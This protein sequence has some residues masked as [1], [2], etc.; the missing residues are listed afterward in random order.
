[1]K[2]VLAALLLFGITPATAGEFGRP[3]GC[4]DPYGCP[5]YQFTPEDRYTTITT[6]LSPAALA[7]LQKWREMESAR[8]ANDLAK[9]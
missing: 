1:M 6:Q 2:T 3:P 5:P 8:E 9:R 4:E 7:A